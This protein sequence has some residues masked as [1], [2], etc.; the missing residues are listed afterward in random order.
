[1]LDVAGYIFATLGKDAKSELFAIS[2]K[3]PDVGGYEYLPILCSSNF[4]MSE[5]CRC[6]V[7]GSCSIAAYDDVNGSASVPT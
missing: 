3:V 5:S 6:N 7:K 4:R 2:V 1:M